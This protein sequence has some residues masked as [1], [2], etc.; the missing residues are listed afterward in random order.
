MLHH[1]DMLIIK[2]TILL[3]VSQSKYDI[4]IFNNQKCFLS[5]CLYS[6]DIVPPIISNCPPSITISAGDDVNAT[7][8]WTEPRAI[9]NSGRVTKYRETHQPGNE[10]PVGTT[11]VTYIYMDPSMNAAS[12]TFFVTVTCK[13]K[14]DKIIVGVFL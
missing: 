3:P 1:C 14:I 13:L 5:N 12:C 2:C 8:S 10:F 4:T 6:V 9:D 7:V 11:A